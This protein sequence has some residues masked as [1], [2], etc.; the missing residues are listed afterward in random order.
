MKPPKL[1][2]LSRIMG[3]LVLVV[4]VAGAVAGCGPSNSQ[5]QT[6]NQAPVQNE[7]SLNVGGGGG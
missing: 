5:G 4:L 7:G 6:G 1:T 2:L 3:C